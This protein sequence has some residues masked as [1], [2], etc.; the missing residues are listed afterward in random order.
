[1]VLASFLSVLETFKSHVLALTPQSEV[2]SLYSAA[3]NSIM[4]LSIEELSSV[5]SLA[6]L[7]LYYLP[8]ELRPLNEILSFSASQGHPRQVDEN[9]EMA[10]EVYIKK[11]FSALLFR[12]FSLQGFYP[13]TL[14]VKVIQTLYA[15][16]LDYPPLL[17]QTAKRRDSSLEALRL[18]QNHPASAIRGALVETQMSLSIPPPFPFFYT[19]LGDEEAYIAEQARTF[20]LRTGSRLDSLIGI[21]LPGSPN[22]LASRR[23]IVKDGYSHVFTTNPKPFFEIPND[24]MKNDIL[25]V[26]EIRISLN[27]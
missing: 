22:W 25:T 9:M 13:K 12:V 14:D 7:S 23:K 20:F 1:M 21:L 18:L 26:L 3:C 19:L 5:I 4:Y 10:K 24:Y 17:V 27:L 16:S 2:P 8:K 6:S 11:T 15:N